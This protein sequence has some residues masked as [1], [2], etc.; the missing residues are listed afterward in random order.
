MNLLCVDLL[1]KRVCVVCPPR[2]CGDKCHSLALTPSIPLALYPH[3]GFPACVP[4]SPRSSLPDFPAPSPFVLSSLHY[5]IM[6][7][8]FI[9]KSQI[10]IINLLLSKYMFQAHFEPKTIWII[11]SSEHRSSSPIFIQY[12][13]GQTHSG[14]LGLE[15]TASILF[16]SVWVTYSEHLD[17]ACLAEVSYLRTSAFDFR[18]II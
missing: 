2:S 15:T 13:I 6:L 12:L 14:L 16:C 1:I 8:F 4:S 18:A 5:L 3:F 10:R 17:S 9:Q 11:D 7:F